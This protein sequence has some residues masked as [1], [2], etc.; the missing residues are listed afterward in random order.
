MN[1]NADQLP[2]YAKFIFCFTVLFLLFAP[3]V[4]AQVIT[5]KGV[6]VDSLTEE[7]LPY[8]TIGI[9]DNVT[10]TAANRDGVFILEVPEGL[11]DSVIFFSYMGYKTFETTVSALKGYV[12]IRLARESISLEEIKVMPWSPW[13]YVWNAMEHIPEN[14]ALKPYNTTGY[15][16]EYLS[17]NDVFLKFTEA[18]VET[19]YPPYGV[20]D[21]IRTKIL[22]ARSMDDPGQIKFMRKKLEKKYEK[23]KKKT[24]KKGKSWGGKET[25]D[26]EIISST[27]GGPEKILEKDPLRDTASFLNIKNRKKFIYEIDGY[28]KRYGQQ[29]I[30]IGYRSK[31]VFDHQRKHGKIFISLESGAILAIEYHTEVVVPVLARPVLFVMG[32]GIKNPHVNV[33]VQYRPVKGRWYVNDFTLDGEVLMVKKKIFGK[34]ENSDFKIHM[35]LINGSFDFENVT[36]IP[37]EERIKDNV[38]LDQQAEPDPGFWE[39]YK[40]ARPVQIGE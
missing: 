26:E 8:A 2:G 30:V 33:F 24:V 25:I 38:P 5:V 11:A 7:P 18:V 10:G 36:K 16:S 19:W 20:K 1:I 35:S 21:S 14:Y 22:K 23:E 27:F 39:N 13:D 3:A 40:V 6:V 17:E 31:G 37:D 4:S 32:I 34:N 29:V 15:Y 12:T 28:T 9:K